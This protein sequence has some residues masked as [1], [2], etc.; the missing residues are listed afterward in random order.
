MDSFGS[1]GD[2]ICF[3]NLRCPPEWEDRVAV[4]RLGTEKRKQYGDYLVCA[5]KEDGTGEIVIDTSS[6]VGT[7]RVIDRSSLLMALAIYPKEI[8]WEELCRPSI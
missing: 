4:R 5:G 2:P 6:E 8:I 7:Q 3:T 1:D